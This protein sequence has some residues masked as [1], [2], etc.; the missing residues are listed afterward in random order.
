MRLATPTG[1]ATLVPIPVEIRHPSGLLPDDPTSAWTF[2]LTLATIGLALVTVRV[3]YRA[4][5]VERSNATLARY[6]RNVAA[7]STTNAIIEACATRLAILTKDLEELGT[8][9][10]GEDA[11]QGLITRLL[12]VDIADAYDSGHLEQLAE[13]ALSVYE[14]LSTIASVHERI[15]RIESKFA[16]AIMDRNG[17]ITWAAKERGHASRYALEQQAYDEARDLY[18]ETKIAPALK[19]T[20][21]ASIDA[22]NEA[23]SKLNNIRKGTWL[24]APV[25]IPPD[26]SRRRILWIF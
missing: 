7:R 6:H 8:F 19:K 20:K 26:D 9:R 13:A 5:A 21:Q 4:L 3:T 10:S 14:A 24:K 25:S 11:L 18:R 15:D 2:G 12:D 1:T 16:A 17:L 22:I 23:V